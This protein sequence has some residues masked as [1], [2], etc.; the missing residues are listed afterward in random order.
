[1]LLK[2]NICCFCC[3]KLLILSKP[4]KNRHHKWKLP[5]EAVRRQQLRQRFL[6]EGLPL[7]CCQ[8]VIS[9]KSYSCQHMWSSNSIF[10]NCQ[11]SRFSEIFISQTRFWVQSSWSAPMLSM[12][13]KATQ[14]HCCRFSTKLLFSG[15]KCWFFMIIHISS[16][17]NWKSNEKTTFVAE[18]Q[19]FC[20][21]WATVMFCCSTH[22]L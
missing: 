20:W 14:H 7:T 12:M 8:F 13:L 10:K 18:K 3:Q 5:Y 1:M 15:I 16:C 19:Q 4:E 11:K 6:P 22:H 17:K 2:N 21:K 9:L